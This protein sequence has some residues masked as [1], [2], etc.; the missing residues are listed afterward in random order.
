MVGAE[1]EREMGVPQRSGGGRGRIVLFL[2]LLISSN[3]HSHLN[4]AHIVQGGMKM[5]NAPCSRQKCPAKSSEGR[6]WFILLE[7]L[8]AAAL[9]LFQMEAH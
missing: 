1:R 3:A 4:G 8:L 2:F 6:R 7:T 9:V 5:E